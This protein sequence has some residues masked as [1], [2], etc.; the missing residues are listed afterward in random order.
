VKIDADFPGGRIDIVRAPGRGTVELAIEEDS[1]SDVRQW[2]CFRAAASKRREIALVNASDATFPSAW[3]DYR[4]MACAD[5]RTWY[6]TDTEYE[7][8]VLR[9]VHEP[10]GP[11]VLYAY[12]ATYPLSRLERLLQTVSRQDHVDVTLAATTP[13]GR[14]VPVVTFGDPDQGRTIW[15]IARQH[16]GETP[17]SWA[18]EGLIRR[19]ADASDPVTNALLSRACVFVAPLVNPDGAELGNH[20]TSATGVNLNRVWDDPDEDDAPE[21]AALRDAI[22]GTGADLFID[23]HADESALH[24]F[25]AASEGNPSYDE[26]IAA[27][28]ASLLDD[29]AGSCQEFLDEP[30]YDLDEPGE[31]DLSCA[32]NQIGETFGCPS[33]TLELP[34]KD[35]GEERVRAGWSP[36]RAGRFGKD[37]VPVLARALER[38]GDDDRDD[39]GDGD[40]DRD[41]DDE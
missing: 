7:D 16:P 15:V 41:D 25:A 24:A 6:R 14:P 10:R 22:R 12:F 32:A 37:L 33:I 23:V 2:F 40:D 17:A 3:P 9:F 29:L 30:F 26:D 11:E 13:E 36:L 4:V 31:A 28:E 18:V 20:R 19:L 21:V 8:G 38:G 34:M 39:D 27:A 1:A 35:A 5:G